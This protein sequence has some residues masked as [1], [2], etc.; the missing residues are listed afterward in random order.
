MAPPQGVEDIFERIYQA[1]KDTRF[2]YRPTKYGRFVEGEIDQWR[3]VHVYMDDVTAG[4]YFTW[5]LRTLNQQ[6]RLELAQ[7]APTAEQFWKAAYEFSPHS[8]PADAITDLERILNS[9]R[10][11]SLDLGNLY[12]NTEAKLKLIPGLAA[13][14]TSKETDPT[15]WHYAATDSGAISYPDGHPS[16]FDEPRLIIKSLEDNRLR[17]FASLGWVIHVRPNGSWS[18][19]GHA[20]V[21][22]MDEGR[23]RHPWIVLAS[24]WPSEFE[25]AEG[26]FTTYAEEKVLRD[27]FTQLGVLPGGSNR[28]PV[29]KLWTDDQDSNPI[30]MLK[31]FGPEFK[32]EVLRLDGP[33][34]H[35]EDSKIYGPDLAYVM[36][37]YWDPSKDEE[38][39]F[40]KYGKEYMRYNPR[41]MEYV[42]PE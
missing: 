32:F 18:K 10:L 37:W 4:D 8:T 24:H 23:N 26:N 15:D 42:Y 21:M 17:R 39:C 36:H 11:G 30:P 1:A 7:P 33:R 31:R 6:K 35:S 14:P 40:D 41:I 20:L 3:R 9:K 13:L 29:A 16:K 38:V 5:R 27:D 2:A 22:D 34:S 19:T 25:D 28:T 12:G